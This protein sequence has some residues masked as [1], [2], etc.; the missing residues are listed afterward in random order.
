LSK[1]DVFLI[2]DSATDIASNRMRR[3]E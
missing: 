3:A 2:S 1:P